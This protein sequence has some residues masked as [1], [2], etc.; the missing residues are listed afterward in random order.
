MGPMKFAREGQS[1]KG[2]QIE[3]ERERLLSPWVVAICLGFSACVSQEKYETVLLENQALREENSALKAR[4]EEIQTRQR[5]PAQEKPRNNM[6]NRELKRLL[7]KLAGNVGGQEGAWNIVYQNIPMAIITSPP[8][9]RMRIV[10]PIPNSQDTDPS[11][12]TEIMKANFDRALDARYALY[13][14]RLWSVFLHPLSSLTEPELGS[15]LSQ[16]ANL[17]KTYGS[18]YS[19]GQ[20]YFGN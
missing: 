14:G 16:V 11:E 17:V 6:T 7:G 1:R 4:P 10:S 3:K 5:T 15:A 2:I 12:L 20:L 13:Q 9:D 19:S 18:T 8:H